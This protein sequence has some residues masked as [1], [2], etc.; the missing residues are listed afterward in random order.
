M[1]ATE[2]SDRFTESHIARNL[3]G[4]KVLSVIETGLLFSE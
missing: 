2:D 1:K 4:Q 3:I